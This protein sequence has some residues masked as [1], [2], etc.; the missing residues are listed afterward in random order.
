[1]WYRARLKG[2]IC[3]R[4]IPSNDRDDS[5]ESAADGGPESNHCDLLVI[6]GS[7]LT[8]LYRKLTFKSQ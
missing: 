7:N 6:K 8:R 2:R 4:R 1:M 3:W 5:N